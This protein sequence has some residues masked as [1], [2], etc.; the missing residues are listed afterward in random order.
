MKVK[1]TKEALNDGGLCSSA[2]HQGFNKLNWIDLNAGKTI[3]VDSIPEIC[4][5]KIEQV[6]AKTVKAAATKKGDK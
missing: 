2:S 6:G 5:D 3:E 4:K 1:L